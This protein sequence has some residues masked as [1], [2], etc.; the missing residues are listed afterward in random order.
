MG[1]DAT[2]M[3]YTSLK[4]HSRLIL[5]DHIFDSRT[6]L[7]PNEICDTIRKQSAARN[8]LTSR[9]I[10]KYLTD[11][12]D[13]TLRDGKDLEMTCS[14]LKE[15]INLLDPSSKLLFA[16]SLTE[17]QS[18]HGTMIFDHVYEV[19]DETLLELLQSN[20]LNDRRIM[21]EK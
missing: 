14:R 2:A 13:T 4:D 9:S 3:Y 21:G 11:R 1:S 16:V 8:T 10:L 6:E 7:L 18:E 5:A 17:A 15:Y 19:F 20:N 12:I